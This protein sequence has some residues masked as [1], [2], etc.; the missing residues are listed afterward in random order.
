MNL[1]ICRFQKIEFDIKKIW[2]LFLKS[3]KTKKAYYIFFD[4]FN[5]RMHRSGKSEAQFWS[6]QTRIISLYNLIIWLKRI[7][8]HSSSC[9]YFFLD[10]ALKQHPCTRSKYAPF[11]HAFATLFQGVAHRSG[12]YFK[13]WIL[14]ATS[15]APFYMYRH[16][17]HMKYS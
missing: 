14:L 10:F 2:I 12:I 17:V 7:V 4:L 5:P 11:S 1:Q 15:V 3:F 13:L 6:Y 9:V 16:K 8:G